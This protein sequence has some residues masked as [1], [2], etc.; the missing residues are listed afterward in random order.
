MTCDVSIDLLRACGWEVLEAVD[1]C[2][3][4]EELV[5]ALLQ[6]EESQ[7]SQDK[8]SVVCYADVCRIKRAFGMDPDQ[9]VVH[10]VVYE[11]FSDIAPRGDVLEREWNSGC[12]G[13][14][15]GSE[16]FAALVCNTIA[17][18]LNNFMVDSADFFP[19]VAMI[20][21]ERNILST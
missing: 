1:C 11:Y 5:K 13:L 19:A 18:H 7:E 20:W 4:V 21:H 17:A 3:D 16:N 8:P 9:F 2:F 10:T 6:A 15:T 14:S 12:R